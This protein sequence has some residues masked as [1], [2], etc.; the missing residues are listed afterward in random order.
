M[1]VHRK[2]ALIAL[3]CLALPL[4]A[5]PVIDK[6]L[7]AASRANPVF[8]HGL[9]SPGMRVV[10]LGSGLGPE[11]PVEA[12]N[13][14]PLPV[15]GLA[16]VT[17][18]IRLVGTPNWDDCIVLL[19]SATKLGVVLPN[20]AGTGNSELEVSYN[21]SAVKAPLRTADHAPGLYTLNGYGS[22]QANAVNVNSQTNTKPNSILESAK[23]GQIVA[24]AATGLGPA[25]GNEALRPAPGTFSP[26][27]EVWVGGKKARVLYAGRTSCCAG[28]D[29]IDFQVPSDVPTG[30]YVSVQLKEGNVG[31][32]TA[33]IAVMPDG[34]ACS[35]PSGLNP[36]LLPSVLAND[37]FSTGRITLLRTKLRVPLP[38]GNTSESV[39]DT[40]TG[41]FFTY[42]KDSFLKGIPEQPSP[43]SCVTSYSPP[44]Q[45][46][47][48][49][50]GDPLDA[51]AALTVS[52]P[53]D[54]RS[55]DRGDTNYSAAIGGGDSGLGLFLDQ[56]P[57]TISNGDGA[58]VGAFE[59]S[60]DLQPE[61]TWNEESTISLANPLQRLSV[62][63][64]GGD[65]SGLV[66]VA[67]AVIAPDGASA[68][69][70]ACVE[71]NAAGQF[72]IP[73]VVLSNMPVNSQGL[74]PL[75][76]FVAS[77]SAPAPFAAP[78]LDMATVSHISNSGTI[79]IL[80]LDVPAGTGGKR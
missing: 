52:G 46:N 35:D 53:T 32:N 19:A 80:K 54:S 17:V 38:D 57:F 65:P 24:L 50:N 58:A 55:I 75:A 1:I 79:G 43:G 37:S 36:D 25:N 7:N 16:G 78:G 64:S 29:E 66:E 45:D 26:L 2:F 6:V 20:T 30:C 70:F 22:G 34:G 3:L 59:A 44:G 39:T 41:N 72:T 42:G 21:G 23:P 18:R 51:G 60:T 11:T 13:S 62:T 49:P 48:K 67:G 10:I 12:P 73:D 47:P 74:A 5:Q 68:G 9:I 61:F 63:W 28:L 31:S 76:L 33:T 69:A 27:P 56:G 4:A 15:K 40:F 8:Q 77:I 71:R 14:Y